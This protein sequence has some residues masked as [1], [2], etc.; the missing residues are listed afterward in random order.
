MRLLLPLSLLLAISSCKPTQAPAAFAMPPTPVSL[1]SIQLG[2]YPWA[3]EFRAEIR[4]SREAI[5][6]PR[7]S[8]IILKRGYREGE[9]VSAGQ[10][11]FDID[12]RPY[13]LKQQM[14]EAK[15]AESEA[16]AKSAEARIGEAEARLHE[17]KVR[18]EEASREAKRQEQLV[19]AEAS[20]RRELDAAKTQESLAQATIATA[21]SSLSA[22][23]AALQSALTLVASARSAVEQAK[24]ERSWCSV[25][26]PVSGL[27]SLQRIEEG[28]LVSPETELC[29]ISDLSELHCG[30]LLGETEFR[31]ITE[32]LAAKTLVQKS[33]GKL[34]FQLFSESGAV[35]ADDAEADVND[36]QLDAKSQTRILRCVIRKVDGRISPGQLV[37]ARLAGIVIPEII[38]VPR[39]CVFDGSMGKFVYVAAPG[40]DMAGKDALMSTPRPV[41]AGRWLSGPK[42]EALWE[43]SGGIK[44]GESIVDEGSAKLRPMPSVVIDSKSLSPAAK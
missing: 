40:K 5:L 21:D 38:A 34:H 37:R 36:W 9:A 35:L 22:T 2:E 14:A 42:G 12:P 44:P 30:I 7:V 27:S 43:I 6:R 1:L 20:T 33:P 4:A 16:A 28:S 19:A 25:T 41:S 23:R 15:L 39:H 32:K 10:T 17:T 18:L 24:L 31:A 11:L 3:P 29:R 13:D 8:G 26:A